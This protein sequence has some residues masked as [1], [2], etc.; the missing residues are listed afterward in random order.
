MQCAYAVFYCYLWPVLF[1]HIFPHYVISGTIF[2]R[3]DIEFKNVFIFSIGSVC[4][5]FHPKKN[6]ASCYHKNIL[7]F[8]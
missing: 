7:V 1:Y 5:I 2:G 8:V 3:R 4:N 6:S